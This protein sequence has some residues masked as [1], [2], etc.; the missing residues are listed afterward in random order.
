MWGM[1]WDAFPGRTHGTFMLHTSLSKFGTRDYHAI[2]GEMFSVSNGR[3][4]SWL[5]C[6]MY[7]PVHRIDFAVSLS[8]SFH[9]YKSR[10]PTGC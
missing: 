2:V 9:V 4:D 10:N 5:C 8:L 3:F 6:S 7:N 1:R